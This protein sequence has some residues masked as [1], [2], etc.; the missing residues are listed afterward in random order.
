MEI[1]NYL[2]LAV[3]FASLAIAGCEN[4]DDRTM[5]NTGIGAAT[6]AVVGGVAAEDAAEGAAIGAAVGGAGGYGYSK[7]TEDE[8]EDDD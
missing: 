2:L 7:A 6:G 3:L 4:V 8:E 5:R 1:K